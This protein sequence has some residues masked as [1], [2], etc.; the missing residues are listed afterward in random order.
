MDIQSEK[1]IP[2]F[3]EPKEIIFFKS[4]SYV[5]QCAT[6]NGLSVLQLARPMAF[7]T[8]VSVKM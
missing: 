4:I 5:L 8:L 1:L 3:D 7:V 6:Q 2:S